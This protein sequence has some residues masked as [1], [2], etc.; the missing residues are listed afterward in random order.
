MPRTRSTSGKRAVTLRDVAERADVSP[1]TASRALSNGTRPMDE[2][3]RQRVIDAAAELRYVSN[4]PAQALASKTSSVV[5][6]LVHDVNDPYYSTIASGAM[7]VAKEHGLLVMMASTHRD[8]KLQADYVS[9][10]RAQRAR[11][12]LLAGGLDEGDDD[13]LNDEL[14]AFTE[15]GGRV[16]AISS[17][18]VKGD[19]IA[20]A[21]VEG[22]REVARL[23]HRLGHR[24]VGVVTG[25]P[26]LVSV[27]ERL[28][29]FLDE[30]AKVGIDVD[31][32]QWAQ[33]DFTR[34]GGRTATHQM[35][36]QSTDLTAVFALNDLMAVGVLAA[37]RDDFRLRVPDEVSLVG[38]DDTPA[39]LDVTP[40]LTTVHLPLA[41]MGSQ[42]MTLALETD[43]D[44]PRSVEVACELV[45]RASTAMA[46]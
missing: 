35:F 2:T 3:L 10:L 4:G 43:R 41:D 39:A 17:R 33:G 45:E 34:E 5:G 40:A 15:Q 38:F 16:V 13:R 37:L 23:L 8:G 46:P 20:P 31:N 24:K 29:G 7:D 12:I 21:N 14:D 44:T 6:L 25:P 42:A 22:A 19:A 27:Q 30:G 9:R 26:A 32:S 18:G 36:A 11:A 28:R 1:A